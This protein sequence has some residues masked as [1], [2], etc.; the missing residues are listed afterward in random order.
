MKIHLEDIKHLLQSPENFGGQERWQVQQSF[1]NLY[2]AL[3]LEAPKVICFESPFQLQLAIRRAKG[4]S[5]AVS[6]RNEQFDELGAFLA[7]GSFPVKVNQR[8]WDLVGNRIARA[9]FLA[10]GQ[11]DEVQSRHLRLSPAFQQIEDAVKRENSRLLKEAGVKPEPLAH[12]PNWLDH[13]WLTNYRE[14]CNEIPLAKDLLS[15]LDSGLMQAYC[16]ETLVLWCPKPQYV[17][18][19]NDCLHHEEGPALMWNDHYRLYYWTGVPVPAKLIEAPNSVNKADIEK[20]RNAE[21]RR[22]FQE[23]LGTERFASLFDL[24]IIDS[25]RDGQ[26][27]EQFLY[28]SHEIDPVAGEYIQF[29]KVTCPTTQRDYFLCVPPH[30]DNVWDAVAWTFSKTSEEYQP[31]REV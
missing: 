19:E 22:C 30:L 15:I 23:K 27:N 11:E 1:E 9:L 3:A 5:A 16:F 2:H 8:L 13:K 24:Q 29:A 26:G 14:Q 12:H 20:H 17:F 18:S 25:D 4:Q 31:E 28:R 6:I 21:V 7:A 10:F